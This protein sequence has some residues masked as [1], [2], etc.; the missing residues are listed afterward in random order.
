MFAWIRCAYRWVRF[1]AWCQWNASS[2]NANHLVTELRSLGKLGTKLGQYLCNRPGLCDSTMKKTLS[3]FLYDNPV[4]PIEHTLSVIH[5]AG[6]KGITLGEV[7]GSGTFAQVYRCT[8]D[9]D[10]RPLVLKI[11]HPRDEFEYDIY[12]V[13]WMI[14]LVGWWYKVLNRIDWKEW[15]DSVYAQLDMTN[16]YQTMQRYKTFYLECTE[17]RVPDVIM[18]QS[19]FIIMT[20]ETGTTMD[21]IPRHTSE[22]QRAHKLLT[23]SFLHTGFVHHI[24][25]GDVHEG[26]VLVHERGITLLDFGICVSL[27]MPELTRLL[28]MRIPS[29]TDIEQLLSVLVH[30]STMDRTPLCR[31]LCKHYQHLF[32]RDIAPRFSELFEVVMILV[33]RHSFM[34]RGKMVTYMMNL[35]LLE[36]MSPYKSS[37]D[38]MAS[39]M[40]IIYMKN[41]LFFKEACGTILDTYFNTLGR[42]RERFRPLTT[43]SVSVRSLRV[44]QN[45]M[46]LTSG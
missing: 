39:L 43:E 40:A 12:F 24:M 22:Y 8:L 31:D 6:L 38:Q 3:V 46:K 28:A 20:Y 35:M 21:K 25:H 1:M 45:S 7:V 37:N 36:D 18:G 4:H 23:A 27:S 32:S 15:L 10:P 44:T 14:G 34:V 19:E 5:E 11:N 17:I 9:T 26:N 29:L 33:E 16:E 2:I 13:R 41:N 30:P 42:F